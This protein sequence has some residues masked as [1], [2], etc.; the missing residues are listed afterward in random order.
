MKKHQHNGKKPSSYQFLKNHQKTWVISEEFL[1]C[2]LLQKSSTVSYS[3]ESMI[4]FLHA[5]DHSKLVLEE[6]KVVLRKFIS[7]DEYL[8]NIIR[9]T[10]LL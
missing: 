2:P 6:A 1:L 5:C 10:S 4:K 7:S 3:T 8:N 9:R